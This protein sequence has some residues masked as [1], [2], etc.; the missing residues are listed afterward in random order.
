MKETGK[1]RKGR[2]RGW[3]PSNR[4]ER[5]YGLWDEND[6]ELLVFTIQM[7]KIKTKIEIEEMWFLEV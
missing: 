2:N 6:V 3:R 7:L 4:H 1:S 5:Q